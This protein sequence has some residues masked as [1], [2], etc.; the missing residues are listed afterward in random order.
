MLFSNACQA[1]NLINSSRI[2]WL[3]PLIGQ[4]LGDSE[5]KVNLWAYKQQLELQILQFHVLIA[6]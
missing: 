5:L 6:V 3:T 2:F 4:I 1:L